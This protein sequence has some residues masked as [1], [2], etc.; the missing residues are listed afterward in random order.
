[1]MK[2]SLTYMPAERLP[3]IADRIRLI[4]DY[5]SK[6]S[7]RAAGKYLTDLALRH[8]VEYIIE[9]EDNNGSKTEQGKR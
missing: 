5:E 3:K 1:M 4:K 8:I 2:R 6:N 7:L 9:L